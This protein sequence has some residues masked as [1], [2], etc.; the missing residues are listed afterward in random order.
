MLQDDLHLVGKTLD[1][2]YL[3]VGAIG[4]GGYAYVYRAWQATLSRNVAIKVLQAQ[5][6]GNKSERDDFLAR[7]QQEASIVA[8]LQ[9]HRIIAIYD[10]GKENDLAY[11]VMPYLTHGTLQ[12]ALDHYK[13]F[14]L[15]QTTTYI[16]QAAEALDYAHHHSIVHRDLK[17]S[18]FLLSEHGDLI[19][20]DFGIARLMQQHHIQQA[21]FKTRTD[22]FIG[23]PLYAAPEMIL[24]RDIDHRADLY[25]LGIV[26]FQM[27][28]G[29][30]PFKGKSDYGILHQHVHTPLPPLSQW[31]P[32]ISP[33]VDRVLQKATAKR[34]ED[35]YHSV[36]EFA[37]ALRRSIHPPQQPVLLVQPIQ[38]QLPTLYATASTPEVPPTVLP[39]PYHEHQAQLR[40]TPPQ[41][42]Y[43]QAVANNG[44]TTPATPISPR[45]KSKRGLLAVV[46]S[47]SV[48][49]LISVIILSRSLIHT[50]PPISLSHQT[51]TAVQSISPTATPTLTPDQQ[52]AKQIVLDYYRD[53]DDRHYAQ[54]YL[55]LHPSSKPTDMISSPGICSSAYSDYLANYQETEKH[56]VTSMDV[57]PPDNQQRYTVK[58]VVRATEYL[59][60][61]IRQSTYYFSDLVQRQGSSWQITPISD[62]APHVL[63]TATPST[64]T[65]TVLSEQPPAIVQ[66]YFDALKVGDYPL[67]YSFLSQSYQASYHYCD[68]V[69]AHT[70][71]LYNSPNITL[72]T[73]QTDG[74]ALVTA[75]VFVTDPANTSQAQTTNMV[76]ENF[77][78]TQEQGVWKIMSITAPTRN[79]N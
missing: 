8:K 20:A 16:E 3:L 24:A 54:A 11:L 73:T 67:A 64:T 43:T 28:T 69:L 18:N 58:S 26:C 76:Q 42:V 78:L 75:T 70:G 53:I 60:A 5:T 17:P 34:P 14:S 6:H 27:L 55:L 23:T 61:G 77:I 21:A 2:R 9:H 12:I 33:E 1:D 19:L 35:R 39:T 68:F 62:Y 46:L 65:G 48:L 56:D 49:L 13:R 63:G 66:L 72:A 37:R 25:E 41:P 71:R 31:L 57:S 32:T 50:P 4:Q 51:P 36:G 38:P 10:Y 22:M 59:P 15:Q 30:P 29:E 52:Q 45:Q 74:T 40:L 7:F 79:T 44:L 47:I